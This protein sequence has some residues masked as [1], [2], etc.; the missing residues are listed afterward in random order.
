M[1]VSPDIKS[2]VRD[3]ND[4][5]DIISSYVHLKRHG[6]NYT[7]LCPFHNEKTPSFSVNQRDQYFYCFGCHAGGDVFTFLQ[8]YENMTF[9]EALKFLADRAGI[10]LPEVEMTEE[11]KRNV[12]RKNRI[13]DALK[14]AENFFYQQL[15]SERGE[16]GK[17]YFDSRQLTEETLH[18]FHLGYSLQYSDALVNYLRKKGFS[19]DIILDAGLAGFSERDGLYDKFT[20]RVMFPIYDQAGK[21]IGFG[22]RV[23]GDAKPKYLNSPETAFFEKRKNLY[24]L[25]LARSSKAKQFI[26]CEGYMD[27]ISMHQAGFTQAIASLGTSFTPEQAMLLKRF[28]RDIYLAYDSDGAGTEAALRAIGILR[29]TGMVARVISMQPYKDPDEF[30]KNLGAEEYQKRIDEAENGFLFELRILRKDYRIDD[31]A[32]KTKFETEVAKKLC[33]FSEELERENYLNAAAEQYGI[34]KD[35]LKK[36]VISE[37]ARGGLKT[38]QERV[39]IRPANAEKKS[40]AEEHAKYAQ[41]LLLTWLNEDKSC[42]ARVREY[43]SAEDFTDPLYQKI[44]EKMFADLEAGVFRP[45]EIIGMFDEVGDQEAASEVFQTKLAT[46]VAKEDKEKALRDIVLR[47]KQESFDQLSGRLGS[48]VGALNRVVEGKHI[49]EKLRKIERI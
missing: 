42:F 44:A 1:M 32:E 46:E 19:D 23:M 39:Q 34:P 13:Y 45:V 15:R 7:G 33:V 8:K 43:I 14:T 31:P 17:K 21:V 20:N 40:N 12:N 5:V 49:L 26:L 38:A 27:V 28:D 4:I 2:E 3:R 25:Q 10:T 29:Q 9:P 48:D 30:I 35:S 6:N 22:G 36:R 41:R 47:V 24:G 18:K 16:L 37:A 11:M